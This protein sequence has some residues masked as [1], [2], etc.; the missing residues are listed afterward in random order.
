MTFPQAPTA[1]VTFDVAHVDL[2]FFYDLD[3]AILVV[4]L[5]ADDLPLEQAQDA[6][7]RFGRAYPTYWTDDGR[8]RQLPDRP[9]NGSGA[10]AAC[11]RCRTTSSARII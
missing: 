1:P 7:Y 8:G 9:P 11:A 3:V 2:C 4:E 6:M 10:T 5:F